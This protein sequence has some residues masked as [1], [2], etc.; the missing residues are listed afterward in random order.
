MTLFL[1]FISQSEDLVPLNCRVAFSLTAFFSVG[2]LLDIVENI[3]LLLLMMLILM[4]MLM[5]MVMKLMAATTT[6]MMT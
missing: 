3:S 5:I 4:L 1:K 6:I 2:K